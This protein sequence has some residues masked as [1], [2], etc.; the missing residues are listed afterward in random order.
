LNSFDHFTRGLET[1]G[2]FDSDHALLAHLFHRPGNDVTNGQI[3]VGRNRADLRDFTVI[4]GRL[5][6]L[7]QFTNDGRDGA[8]DPALERTSGRTQ[9]LPS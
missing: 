7:L 8:V 4:L 3:I 9:P 6:Q 5:G 2:L 1:L